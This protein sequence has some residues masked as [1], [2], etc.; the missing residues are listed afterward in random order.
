MGIFTLINENSANSFQTK[1][2]KP[3]DFYRVAS[4]SLVIKT[5]FLDQ[6][7]WDIKKEKGSCTLSSKRHSHQVVK[8]F[9][10]YDRK[11]AELC[12]VAHQFDYDPV[13]VGFEITEHTAFVREAIRN[14][15]AKEAQGY[16]D[17]RVAGNSKWWLKPVNDHKYDIVFLFN[18]ECEYEIDLRELEA[19]LQEFPNS[20]NE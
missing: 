5:H 1:E 4:V 19:L 2:I 14:E 16:I 13:V 15:I 7:S 11:L 6:P 3:G 8:V 12:N 17:P 18:G 9:V 10:D 20:S